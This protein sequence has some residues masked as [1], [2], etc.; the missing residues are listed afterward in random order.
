MKRAM[1]WSMNIHLNEDVK[2]EI[3]DGGIQGRAFD[4]VFFGMAS[5]P[6]ITLFPTTEEQRGWLAHMVEASAAYWAGVEEA[7]RIS[8]R[9]DEA[10]CVERRL[11]PEG[12]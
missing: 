10:E 8:A 9:I 7:K 6:G 5:Y 4:V 12:A 11:Q 1:S 2:P 3:V